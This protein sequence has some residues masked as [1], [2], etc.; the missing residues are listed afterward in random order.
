MYVP[1]VIYR[2]LSSYYLQSH[3]SLNV[4]ILHV[5]RVIYR[6]LSSYYLQSHLSSELLNFV[7]TPC[8]ISLSTQLLPA[9]TLKFEC[10]MLYVPRVIYRYLSSYYLQSHLSLN[11]WI[12]YVPRVIYR[13][14]SSYYLRS[15]LSSE[16]LNFVCTPCYI[17]LSIQ[18]L[19]AITLNFWMF[20]FCMYP[21]LYIAIYPVI[22]CNHT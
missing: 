3:L 5:P 11:V 12:L 19:P 18:L 6:Y 21:V 9:I 14:L 17:S 4:W 1:R 7:C 10:W 16:C 2:Y 8:Y 22:I 15:H 13:Y 20:E